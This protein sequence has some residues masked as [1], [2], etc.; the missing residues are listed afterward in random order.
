MCWKIPEVGTTLWSKH[1]GTITAYGTWK[2]F[3]SPPALAS[4]NENL[5][6]FS[7]A[8][9]CAKFNEINNIPSQPNKQITALELRLMGLAEEPKGPPRGSGSANLTAA[10]SSSAPSSSSSS[11]S[12]LAHY[13]SNASGPERLSLG[14]PSYTSFPSPTSAPLPK[15]ADQNLWK[16]HPLH[17]NCERKFQNGTVIEKSTI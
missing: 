6:D 16:F 3:M 13:L 5:M 14:P 17:M 10:T 12:G 15:M 7:P 9:S 2:A 11:S 1:G 4:E 8:K